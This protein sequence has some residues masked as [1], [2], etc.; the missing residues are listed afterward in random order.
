VKWW[1][2]SK[3]GNSFAVLQFCSF[4]VLQFC[5]SM[6]LPFYGSAVYGKIFW[7]YPAGGNI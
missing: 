4:S 2:L 1:W 5:G 7:N 6:V 3:Q